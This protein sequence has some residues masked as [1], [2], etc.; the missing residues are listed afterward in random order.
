MYLIS[1]G[2][3]IRI[4]QEIRCLPYAGIFL[5]VWQQT[6]NKWPYLHR[7][8]HHCCHRHHYLPIT[9]WD[10]PSYIIEY[11]N[12]SIPKKILDKLSIPIGMQARHGTHR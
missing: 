8:L 3:S 6:T 5:N 4:G 11:L 10:H 7:R 1:I 12:F 9:H 2:A